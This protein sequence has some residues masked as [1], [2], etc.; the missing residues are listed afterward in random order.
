MGAIIYYDGD[1]PFCAHYVSFLRLKESVGPV[2]LVN[3]R[4][5]EAKKVELLAEGYDLDKGMVVEVS[6]RRVGGADAVHQLALLTTPST[7]FNKIN[8]AI[9]SSAGLASFLYPFLRAGRWLVL[10]LLGREHLS[11]DD[12][13]AR[14]RASIFGSM[15]AL[16]S[17]FHFFNYMLEYGRF[18]PSID[19]FLIL[20]SAI[21]LFLRPQ[22]A[23]LL[24]LLVLMSTVSAIAQAPV[25]SNHTIVRNF[26]L[27]GYWM[28]FFYAMFKSL[29]PSDVFSNFTVAGQGALLVMYFFGV[30]H[31]INTDFLNPETSCAVTLWQKMPA[32]LNLIDTPFMHYLAIYGTFAVEGVIVLM[33]FSRKWR[34]TAIVFGILFHLLLAM[35]NYAMYISFTT[36]AISLHCL[37]LN[38]ESALKIVKSKFMLVVRNRVTNPAYFALAV[39]LVI[40]LGLAGV[41]KNYTLVTALV[42]PLLLPFCWAVMKYG[43]SSKP[44]LRSDNKVRA[45]VIG[46]VLTTLFFLNCWMPYM[47]L[48]SAQSVNMFANIRLEAG[49]SNHLIMKNPPGPFK[50]LEDVVLITDTNGDR[51]LAGYNTTDR[52]MVYYDLLAY[53]SDNAGA[54]LSYE[55]YGVIHNDMTA[56]K[57]K[58]DIDDILHP[59][60]FRKWFHFKEAEIT[61]PEKCWG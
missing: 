5:N 22:S 4:E 55:R 29:K 35:S 10:F 39:L 6:G 49:V 23:R 59:A 32:P 53:L 19:Q 38:E 11:S 24:C 61:Q 1:C 47:G 36:L 33:L 51:R 41:S 14:A 12:E 25:S 58:G 48:K 15:F 7:L 42:L 57:L 45:G 56:E 34:H 21:L 37:F 17:V 50:Y 60:W 40:L 18:P 28:S 30:F 43:A 9:M 20:L 16:F 8:K 3:L 46:G 54:K 31:K 52:G 26:V 2:D 44:L 27:L 13:G